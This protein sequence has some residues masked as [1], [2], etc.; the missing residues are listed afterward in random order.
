M[1]TTNLPFRQGTFRE[2]PDS[3]RIPHGFGG[4]VP[5]TLQLPLSDLGPATWVFRKVGQG[6]PLLLVHG[7]MTTGYSW[8]YVIPELARHWTVFVPDLP[9]S[10]ASVA[11]PGRLLPRRM[12]EALADFIV[13]QG[14]GPMDVIGNSMG[15]Y[16]TLHLAHRRPD[17]VKRHVVLHAP[18]FAEA[19]L[20]AL[21]LA[22]R[23][24][25]AERLLGRLVAWDALRWAH[26]NV[27]YYDE[28]LKSLE[29]A[30]EYGLP[31][32]T[33]SG[34]SGFFR[35]LRDMMDV[36]EMTPFHLALGEAGGIRARTLLL[37]ARTDPMVPP[38]MGPAW[39]ALL[40]SARLVWAEEGSH[41]LHVDRPDLFLGASVPFLRDGAG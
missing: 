8:R 38:W 39:Q 14:M 31:L 35:Q 34:R 6:P 22:L 32:L 40:P 18:G 15:G 24:P 41:F 33:P 37:Y 28:S 12:G 2:L 17:L 30:R 7:L 11:P 3:P 21:W 4:L 26:R 5:H 20:W 29:E 25:G 13:A 27:H 19:R 10:G 36:R 1:K 16:L 23:V 9:G